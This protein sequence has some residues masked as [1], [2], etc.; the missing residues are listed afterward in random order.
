MTEDFYEKLVQ[1]V[2]M[3][4]ARKVQKTATAFCSVL[5]N[6]K[7]LDIWV[8]ALSRNIKTFMHDTEGK[9]RRGIS[10]SG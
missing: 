6:N 10:R 7:C 8:I 5:L 9:Q 2:Q 4:C 1:S 3:D